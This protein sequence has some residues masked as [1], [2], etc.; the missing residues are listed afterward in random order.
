MARL[1]AQGEYGTGH[2][3]LVDGKVGEVLILID[4]GMDVG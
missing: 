1:M 3:C 4:M 2:E